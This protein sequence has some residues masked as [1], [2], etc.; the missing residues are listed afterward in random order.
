MTL[1]STL[2]LMFTKLSCLLF[3]RRVFNLKSTRF[4]NAIIY[5]TSALIGMWGLGFFL[6]F[7]FSCAR[8]VSFLWGSVDQATL[9]PANPRQLNL[10]LV[11]SNFL[12]DLGLL[13]FP[14]PLVSKCLRNGLDIKLM[15]TGFEAIY[16]REE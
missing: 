5:V 4:M 8:N 14:I 7:I 15:I 11:I 3:Y 1:C 2:S 13:I 10:G 12:L 16:V 6:G 9:C